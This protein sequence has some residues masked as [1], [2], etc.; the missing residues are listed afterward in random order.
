MFFQLIFS[1]ATNAFHNIL[2]ILRQTYFSATTSTT[3][4]THLSN[5]G[6]LLS[7]HYVVYLIPRFS[8]NTN[9]YSQRR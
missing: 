6:G 2:F 9:V 8:S 1:T 5:D 4:K 3:N 7:I